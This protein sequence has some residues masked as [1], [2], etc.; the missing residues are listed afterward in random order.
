MYYVGSNITP[1]RSNLYTIQCRQLQGFIRCGSVA[2]LLVS[3]RAGQQ[4]L[5]RQLQ[6]LVT[7]PSDC[8]SSRRSSIEPLAVITSPS[9]RT[10]SCAA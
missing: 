3:G 5:H 1:Q 10:V 2:H 7:S 6:T 8:C 4:L 9:S